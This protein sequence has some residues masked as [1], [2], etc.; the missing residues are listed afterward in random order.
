MQAKLDAVKEGLVQMMTRESWKKEWQA[1]VIKWSTKVGIKPFAAPAVYETIVFPADPDVHRGDNRGIFFIYD[2]V[3][4][5]PLPSKKE[6]NVRAATDYRNGSTEEYGLLGVP[7]NLVVDIYRHFVTAF[8][9]EFSTADGHT[10]H[11]YQYLHLDEDDE[12]RRQRIHSI[13]TKFTDYYYLAATTTSS[14]T[15]NQWARLWMDKIQLGGKLLPIHCIEP[16]L[17]PLLKYQT[18]KMIEHY[19]RRSCHSVERGEQLI[20]TAKRF[21]QLL[22]YKETGE[23]NCITSLIYFPTTLVAS[24]SSTNV[25]RIDRELAK[26]FNL[27]A[28]SAQNVS[29]AW[30][31]ALK[32]KQFV[33]YLGELTIADVEFLIRLFIDS[34]H[35][36]QDVVDQ[37]IQLSAQGSPFPTD[38]DEF[39]NFDPIHLRGLLATTVLSKK[40]AKY[41]L[42][43]KEINEGQ[44]ADIAPAAL[45]KI[46]DSY[47][48]VDV[49]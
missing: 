19:F 1:A 11:C 40:L 47:Y 21:A 38:A 29:S 39:D 10:S 2:P 17:R 24:K 30:D 44:F 48:S 49:N 13:L 8:G 18:E 28:P 22:T 12:R 3:T 36:H 15:N 41:A 16:I 26:T 45:V 31:S 37:V 6:Y 33:E 27:N 14:T 9:L 35:D 32:N 23:I 25:N 7:I 46:V 4:L 43:T 34:R 42:G 20:I 5:L